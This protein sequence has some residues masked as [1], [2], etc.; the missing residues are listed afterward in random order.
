MPRSAALLLWLVVVVALVAATS[1]ADLAWWRGLIGAGLALAVIGA[2]L[3]RAI[4]RLGGVTGDVFGAAVELGLA[5]LL[6]GL[7][8]NPT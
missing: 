1:A 8:V 7:L 6:V 4:R 3:A 5:A 2:L